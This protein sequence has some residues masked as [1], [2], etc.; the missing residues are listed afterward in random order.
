MCLPCTYTDCLHSLCNRVQIDRNM[1]KSW[2]KLKSPYHFSFPHVHHPEIRNGM[3]DFRGG[4]AHNDAW[5]LLSQHR[6]RLRTLHHQQLLHHSLLPFME[7]PDAKALVPVWRERVRS[8]KSTCIV[9]FACLTNFQLI[10][11][12]F[13][14][15]RSIK[16]LLFLLFWIYEFSSSKMMTILWVLCKII[17]VLNWDISISW[18]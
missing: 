15:K 11:C 9:H 8:Q 6:S 2:T 13:H 14:Y 3:H 7:V 4:C 1:E 18:I 17:F 12:L 5:C 16:R 10:S